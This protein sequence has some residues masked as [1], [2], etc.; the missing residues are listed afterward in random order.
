MNVLELFATFGFRVDNSGLKSIKSALNSLR[1]ATA[2]VRLGR[3]VSGLVGIA[4]HAG[5]T[6]THLISSSKALGL[7]MQQTQ[8][9]GYIAEQ[10]GSNIKEFGVGLSMYESNLRK[11]ANGTAGKMVRAQFR[12]MGIDAAKA[13][14]TIHGGTQSISNS[15]LVVSKRLK[16]M[17]PNEV[18]PLSRGL[19]GARAGRAMAADLVRGPEAIEAL[20]KR[21]R[22]MGELDEKDANTLRELHNRT[23]DIHRSFNAVAM[24]VVAE[25]APGFIKLAE[26]A[27]Q[28]VSANREM[29]SGVL[30]AAFE[31]LGAVIGV[32]AKA[33]SGLASLIKAAFAGDAG[34][35]AALAGLAAVIVTLVLPSIVAMGVAI[36]AALGPALLIGL[37]IAAVVLIVIKLRKHWGDIADFFE[38][39]W[40]GITIAARA[41]WDWLMDT[42]TVVGEAI[43]APINALLDA[44]SAVKEAAHDAL[45]WIIDKVEAIGSAISRVFGSHNGYGNDGQYHLFNVQQ[46]ANA[47]AS[48]GTGAPAAQTGGG[49]KSVTVGPTTVTINDVKDAAQA[50]EGIRDAIDNTHRHAAAALGG[51][52]Q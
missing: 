3:I 7:T 49:A 41:F 5:E 40:N 17:N 11:V 46:G 4:E 38:K 52:V 22:A 16:D 39:S 26:A 27:V 34:A 21:R 14:Q 48:A 31:A 29:I 47:P 8:E 10:S 12:D 1:A 25:V 15:L 9:W 19:F 51:E 20:M 32:I 45:D 2:G 36:Y 23:E 42:A 33:I 13:Q 35:T 18:G 24:K 28:W 37:A 6:A 43:M 30:K 44:W 50:K